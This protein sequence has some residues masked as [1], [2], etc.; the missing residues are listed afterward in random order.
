VVGFLGVLIVHKTESRFSNRIITYIAINMPCS[1]LQSFIASESALF[2]S[3][4]FI[5]LL[6]DILIN[7]R[8]YNRLKV[9]N[10]NGLI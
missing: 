9:E 4:Y 8:L 5:F 10:A 7:F 6:L 3:I 1:F 2:I